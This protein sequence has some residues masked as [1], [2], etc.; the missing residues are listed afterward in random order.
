MAGILKS[1]LVKSCPS[2]GNKNEKLRFPKL[3][4]HQ[5]SV[6]GLN[7]VNPV[8]LEQG[9][10]SAC[11]LWGGNERH[12]LKWFYFVWVQTIS[13]PLRKLSGQIL[14]N[15]LIQLV[16]LSPNERGVEPYAAILSAEVA[17]AHVHAAVVCWA[18]SQR[19]LPMVR[20]Y[21]WWPQDLGL[22]SYNYGPPKGSTF[23]NNNE[24]KHRVKAR[25]MHKHFPAS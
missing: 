3:T 17:S 7:P 20:L 2:Q 24:T 13:S 5:S 15:L 25:S 22:D 23:L 16:L 11:L 19:V 4:M 10:N 1:V 12:F 14:Q 9:A 6:S 21:A 8:G 18:G